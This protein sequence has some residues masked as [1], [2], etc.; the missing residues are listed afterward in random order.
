[1]IRIGDFSKLSRVSVKT[2]R[3][4]DEMGL[5]KPIEVDA[6]TGYRLYEYSQLSILNRTLRVALKNG[7]P[8]RGLCRYRQ[9]NRGER[10]PHYRRVPRG[11]PE[12]RGEWESDRPNTVTEIQFPVEK[13]WNGEPKVEMRPA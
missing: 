5:L 6:F 12:G 10:L 7:H 4:Y 9:A 11:L 3:Y 2:L 13:A 1:M 8:Q